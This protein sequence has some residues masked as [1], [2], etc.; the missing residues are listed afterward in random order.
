MSAR[1]RRLSAAVITTICTRKSDGAD[2][3]C[4]GAAQADSPYFD[5]GAACSD[6]SRRSLPAVY[7][8]WYVYSQQI[9]QQIATQLPSSGD[10]QLAEK[11][12]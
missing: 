1:S 6:S 2:G 4:A 7:Q 3:R 10:V 12:P 9:K 11:P 8:N 5:S